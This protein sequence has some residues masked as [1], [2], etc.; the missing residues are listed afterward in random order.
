MD[1]VLRDIGAYKDRI[2]S[3]LTGSQDIVSLLLND[4]ITDDNVENLVYSRIFPYLY[5]NNTQTEEQSYLCIEVEVPRIPTKMIKDMKII[6]WAY[7]HKSIMKYSRDDFRGTRADIL[8]DMADRCIT[9]SDD[10]G[11]GRPAL[12]SDTHFFPNDN[13]YG[14]QLIYTISDFK[15]KSR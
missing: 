14:R 15:V 6:V 4:T 1:S 11:I 3:L 10:F 7:C 5:V 2:I 8:A 12:E 9:G 13:H